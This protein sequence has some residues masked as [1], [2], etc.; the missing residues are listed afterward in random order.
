MRCESPDECDSEDVRCTVR[1]RPFCGGIT[2]E[3][4]DQLYT[5]DTREAVDQVN[6]QVSVSLTQEQFDALASFAFN[7]GQ[8]GP[9]STGNTDMVSLINQYRFGEAADAFG[10]YIY[11]VG[12]RE[13]VDGLVAR[14]AE[15]A[16]M[17]RTGYYDYTR[18]QALGY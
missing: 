18:W 11:A 17:F 3:Q 16:Q 4:G 6:V 12:W 8:L 15:E 10:E 13:P 9:G 1:E 5:D 7:R 2:D 14:R